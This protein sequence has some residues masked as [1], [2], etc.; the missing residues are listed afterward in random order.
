VQ[1]EEPHNGVYMRAL[2]HLY[3][4]LPELPAWFRRLTPG[5]VRDIARLMAGWYTPPRRAGGPG[6]GVD[7][8]TSIPTLQ[9]VERDVIL[10]AIQL[11]DGDVPKAAAALHI[12]KTTV[13]RKIRDWG[14]QPKAVSQASV[15]A[16]G[17][18]SETE[19]AHK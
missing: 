18:K 15:L 4:S 6:T 1:C 13:Y 19:T 10:R 11:T 14:W 16:I 3:D 12:G 5:Q 2:G 9:S 7:E 8:F 17:T